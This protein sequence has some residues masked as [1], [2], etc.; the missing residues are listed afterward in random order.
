MQPTPPAAVS[1]SLDAVGG[2]PL[3]RLAAL[4]DAAGAEVYVKIESFNPTA[5]YKDRMARAMIEKAE[6]RGQLRPGM[7]VV[8]Y[9]GGSTG[10]SLAFVCAVKGYPLTIV[11]SDAFAQE[12]L[13]TMR[14]FGADVVIIPSQGGAITGDLIAAMRARAQELA[15]RDDIYF[16]DQFNNHDAEDGYLTLGQEIAQQLPGVAHAFCAG[17]GTAG[18]LIGTAAG[19]RQT[20]PGCRVVAL[21]PASSPI[22]TRGRSG[23]HRIEGTG[24]GIVP[25]LL[26][27]NSYDEAR[28]VDES[29]A[30][31]TAREL[32]CKAGVLAGT[33]SGMNVAAA[34]DLAA[35]LGSGHNV[36]TAVVDSGLKYLAGDLFG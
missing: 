22:L 14:A 18:M 2:T 31:A 26:L 30:R 27:P 4:T 23:K 5:S 17:V 25:P 24:V 13:K 7:G 6:E 19:I 15:A 9:S 21:E 10:S 16:T 20:H 1:S 33:S 29:R 36:V 35:E 34:L 12:K 3:L 8:E 32:A 28:T 11:S